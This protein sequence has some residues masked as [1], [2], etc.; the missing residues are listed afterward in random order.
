MNDGTFEALLDELR[1]DVVS[2]ADTTTKSS[3]R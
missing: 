1:P 3:L 2:S